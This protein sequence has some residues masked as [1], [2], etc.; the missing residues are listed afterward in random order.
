[1]QLFFFRF[2]HTVVELQLLFWGQV[3]RVALC[4][5][6]ALAVMDFVNLFFFCFSCWH[7]LSIVGFSMLF[8]LDVLNWS[9]TSVLECF[10]SYLVVY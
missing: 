10:L 7:G 3:F 4:S 9:N 8:G 6:D 1:M 5:G 2:E